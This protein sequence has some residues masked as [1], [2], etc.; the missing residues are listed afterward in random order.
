[1]FLRRSLLL[2]RSPGT[3]TCTEPFHLLVKYTRPPPLRL[4][5][6]RP[7]IHGRTR[8]GWTRL[9]MP[10]NASINPGLF[11]TL[12]KRRGTVSGEVTSSTRRSALRATL[13]IVSRGAT[14][15]ASPT[16]RMRQ[17]HWPRR[18]ST[19]MAPMMRVRCSSARESSQITCPALTPTMRLPALLTRARSLPTLV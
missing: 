10:G 6:T 13:S 2:A 4:V 11:R 9:T 17:S 3:P 1:L 7:L 14:W 15:S 19:P 12:T 8:A 16:P 5:S 18:S